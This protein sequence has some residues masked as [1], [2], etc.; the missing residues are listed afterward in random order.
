MLQDWHRLLKK[1]DVRFAVRDF[2][3]VSSRVRDVLYLDPPYRYRTEIYSGRFDHSDLWGWLERQRGSY[4]MSLNGFVDG[5]DRRLAVPP[6]LYDEELQIDAGV[7]SLNTNGA[8]HIT[9]SLYLRMR[10]NGR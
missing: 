6:D 1:H 10:M 5:D 7:G 9:N 2:R 3:E 4:L 8:V